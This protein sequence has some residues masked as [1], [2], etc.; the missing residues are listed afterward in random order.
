MSRNFRYMELPTNSDEETTKTTSVGKGEDHVIVPEVQVCDMKS[1]F[2]KIGSSTKHCNQ[3]GK[4]GG[5]LLLIEFI[6]T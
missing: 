5:L 6:I 2:N 4:K 1:S 3:R